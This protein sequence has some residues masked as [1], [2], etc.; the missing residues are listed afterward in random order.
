M[1]T[2]KWTPLNLVPFNEFTLFSPLKS[3]HILLLYLIWVNFNLVLKRKLQMEDRTGNMVYILFLLFSVVLLFLLFSYI[4][5]FY[6]V[7]FYCMNSGVCNNVHLKM[8]REKTKP[9]KGDIFRFF[10]YQLNFDMWFKMEI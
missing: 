3:I 6:L 8:R 4:C 7:W 10:L 1:S 9:S 2:F 5:C